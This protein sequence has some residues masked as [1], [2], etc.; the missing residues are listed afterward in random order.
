[1]ET[2][3]TLTVPG[4]ATVVITQAAADTG[5]ERVELEFSL[6]PGA[7]GPPAHYHPHQEE[8]WHVLAGTLSAYLDGRWSE[9]REGE[10]AAIRR[11]QVHTF[12]NRSASVVR[13]RDVHVP[14]LDFQDYMEELH[15]LTV[16]GKV[17]SLRDPRSL[18]YLA[19]VVRGHRPMQITASAAQR[20]GESF[21]AS[22]AKLL[23]IEVPAAT[24][25]AP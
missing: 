20:A 4:G 25:P 9:L 24:Q 11:G 18:I 15:R 16:T 10:S 13:V 12:R 8:E 3:D 23:R 14:A 22:I 5:G 1:M 2:G 19:M 21:L 6:P 7:G 17:K